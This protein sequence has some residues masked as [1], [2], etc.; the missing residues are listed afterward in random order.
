MPYVQCNVHSYHLFFFASRP[1]FDNDVQDLT[2]DMF[3][4]LLFGLLLAC[5]SIRAE[6]EPAV[7]EVRSALVRLSQGED[8]TSLEMSEAARASLHS[9]SNI[10]MFGEQRLKTTVWPGWSLDCTACEAM[11]VLIIGLFESGTPLEEIETA[12]IRLCITL[13]IESA[14]VCEGMVHGFGYQFEYILNQAENV[15]PGLFCGVF[16][17]GDCGD[18]GQINDWEVEVPGDKPVMEEI[19]GPAESTEVLTVLQIADRRSTWT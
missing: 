8:V 15:T 16:V 13:D 5:S 10:N 9:I 3:S 18:Q 6:S 2:S 12:V 4:A 7:E 1:E 17:G 14:E 11:A 19:D